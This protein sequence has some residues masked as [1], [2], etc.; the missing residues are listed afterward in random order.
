[1][2]TSICVRT[3]ALLPCCSRSYPSIPP[4]DAATRRRSMMRVACVTSGTSENSDNSVFPISCHMLTP[5]LSLLVFLLDYSPGENVDW[6]ITRSSWK[7]AGPGSPIPQSQGKAPGRG[8]PRESRG[9]PNRRPGGEDGGG[10]RDQWG[11]VKS[12]PLWLNRPVPTPFLAS[13]A[14]KISVSR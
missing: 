6:A 8:L 1:M 12:Q 14:A 9:C 7:R 13:G 4:R 11:R 10:P 2:A 5:L 3:P